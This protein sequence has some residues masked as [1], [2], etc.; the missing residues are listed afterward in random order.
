MADSIDETMV[1]CILALYRSASDVGREWAPDFHDI[2]APG[3]ALVPLDDP[4]LTP[5]RVEGTAGQ[6]GA[7]VAELRGVGHWWLMQ[8]PRQGADV[9]EGFWGSLP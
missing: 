3:L 9:L 1:G 8:D 6:A 7:G 2:P 4:F 5:G